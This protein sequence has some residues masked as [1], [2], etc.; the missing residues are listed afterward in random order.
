MRQDPSKNTVIPT[1]NSTA[2][3]WVNWHKLLKKWFSKQEANQRWLAFWGQRAGA[4]S[5]ADTHDLRVYMESQGV[6]LTTTSAGELT[7]GAY[8]VANWFE[9]TASGVRFIVLGAVVVGIGLVAFY[10]VRAANKGKSAAEMV[11]DVRGNRMA[12]QLGR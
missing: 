11:L 1:S 10:F 6:E 3:Q 4:G 2:E 8:K 5:S 9:Q 12:K 7:D